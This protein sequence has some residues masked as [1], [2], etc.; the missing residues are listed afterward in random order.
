M[1]NF[2]RRPWIRAAILDPHS[3]PRCPAAQV[4]DI[5]ITEVT[6]CSVAEV[7]AQARA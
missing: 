7:L 3:L 4:L 2:V 5:G 6:S 1:S